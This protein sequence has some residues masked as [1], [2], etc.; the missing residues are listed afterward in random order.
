MTQPRRARA[1]PRQSAY[2]GPGMPEPV[3]FLGGAQTDFARNIAREGKELADLVRE[4]TLRAVSDAA[5][6]LSAVTAGAST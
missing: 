2:D 4:V 1:R 5:L 6:A 3:F